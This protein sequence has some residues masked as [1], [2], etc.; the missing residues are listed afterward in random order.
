MSEKKTL[1]LRDA[2]LNELA[3]L[4]N[5]GLDKSTAY[6]NVALKYGV[7]GTTIR[8]WVKRYGIP[9]NGFKFCNGELHSV[10]ENTAS[11]T[12]AVTPVTSARAT[13]DQICSELIAAF[14]PKPS[15]LYEAKLKV[16][17]RCGAVE[18]LESAATYMASFELAKKK[19]GY[20]IPCKDGSKV[21][22]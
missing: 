22:F 1:R 5:S 3:K 11:V 7:K 4:E 18:N 15:D 21:Y 10:T 20:P 12:D 19:L 13:S 17:K 8:Q 6:G 16:I 2:V 14:P 9:N